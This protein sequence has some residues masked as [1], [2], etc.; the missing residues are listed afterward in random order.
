MVICPVCG[1]ENGDGAVNCNSCGRSLYSGHVVYKET[2]MGQQRTV[3]SNRLVLAAAAI[4]AFVAVATVSAVITAPDDMRLTYVA[5]GAFA[6]I[7][8]ICIV[9]GVYRATSRGGPIEIGGQEIP[10]VE[11]NRSELLPDL[12]TEE[13][14]DPGSIPKG[15]RPL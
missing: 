9:Y 2:Y 13:T 10:S 3:Y 1:A 14:G 11:E 8:I 6:F 15:L 4:L 12:Q 5:I 7:V